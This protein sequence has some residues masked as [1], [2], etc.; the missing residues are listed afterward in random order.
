MGR[1][2]GI[3]LVL[4]VLALSAVAQDASTM[5]TTTATPAATPGQPMSGALPVPAP[6]NAALPGSGTPVGVAPQIGVNDARTGGA[7]A[8]VQPGVS[9]VNVGGQRVV[10]G[11]IL[12]SAPAATPEGAPMA[13]P[14]SSGAELSGPVQQNTAA[15]ATTPTA[16]LN[17]GAIGTFA[18]SAT[19]PI[20][21]A[22]FAAQLRTRKPLEKRTFDNNDIMAL[23]DK[24]PAG[25]RTQSDDLPQGDAPAGTAPAKKPAAAGKNNRALDENDL[26][27]VE[28]ALAK[29]KKT[30]ERP[31]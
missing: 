15:A 14:A 16:P 4:T 24:A 9:D 31:K 2:L 28:K 1:T 30:E 20:S 12:L 10:A 25:L 13:Q 18:G 7:G 17:R 26:R 11:P 23:N 21:L 8:V 5:T 29:N 3:F 27:E 19:R 22:E 6:P